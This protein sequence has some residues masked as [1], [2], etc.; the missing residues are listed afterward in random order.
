MIAANAWAVYLRIHVRLHA[1]RA[2]VQGDNSIELVT[3]VLR[4][5]NVEQRLTRKNVRNGD[6]RAATA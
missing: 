2:N 6:L 4:P 1:R 3:L 5:R